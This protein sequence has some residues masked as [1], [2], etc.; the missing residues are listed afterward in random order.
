MARENSDPWYSSSGKPFEA[1]DPFFHNPE[2]FSWIEG[3]E[4][5][6]KTIHDELLDHLNGEDTKLIPYVNQEMT[7]KPGQWKTMG[8][9][10][11][12]KKDSANYKLFPKTMKVLEDVPNLIAVSFNSLEP[13]TSIKPHVGDTNAIIRCHLGL[14]I[15]DSAPKCG[16]RVGD[17]TRSWENGKFLMFSDAYMHTAWNN[18]KSKRYIMVL[19]IIKDEYASKLEPISR[20][21]LTDI[22]TEAVIQ[23]VKILKKISS[24]SVG[25][26]LV[27]GTVGLFFRLLP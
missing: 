5:Q 26:S 2:D 22:Y 18:T 9:M 1:T 17:Q 6:W 15:P 23:R 10:F 19:D 12:S 25:K 13:E 16:F 24:T 8:L 11:W 7:S 21:V 14:V 4:A 3:I 27:A 20:K